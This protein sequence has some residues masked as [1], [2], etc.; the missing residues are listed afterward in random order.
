MKRNTTVTLMLM[1]GSIAAA[2]ASPELPADLATPVSSERVATAPVLP[3]ASRERGD[4]TMQPSERPSGSE[5]LGDVTA[6][7]RLA[8]HGTLK[9]DPTCKLGTS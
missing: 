1:I 4:R 9:L 5:C 2:V 8:H 7:Y 6:P 3:A